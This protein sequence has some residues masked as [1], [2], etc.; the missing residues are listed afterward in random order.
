[1]EGSSRRR[2]NVQPTTPEHN[3]P[4]Q[5]I[6]EPRKLVAKR[7][8]K[9]S[10]KKT[11]EEKE[12]P[13]MQAIREK[14]LAK[15][16]KEKTSKTQ[17][18]NSPKN[19]TRSSTLTNKKVP[20]NE[21]D[22]S[23]KTSC[24]P[25]MQ[26]LLE[27]IGMKKSKSKSKVQK[28][29]VIE[30][31]NNKSSENL[32]TKQ[33]LRNKRRKDQRRKTCDPSLIAL[34]TTKKNRKS[35]KK[36]MGKERMEKLRKSLTM[37]NTTNNSLPL[38]QS[39][40]QKHGD[41]LAGIFKNIEV[42]LTRLRDE[43][44]K[45]KEPGDTASNNKKPKI[46][47]VETV[48]GVIKPSNDDSVYEEMDWEPLEDD[49]ITVEVKAVRT[50]LCTVNNE[51]V[52]CSVPNQSLSY[53]LIS[54]M[55]EKKQLYVVVDTNVFLSNINAI[56]LMKET[57]FKTFDH[58]F[59]VIPW[60][61]I[62]E[63]DYIKNSNSK[64]KSAALSMKARKAV[65]YINALFSSKYPYIIGQ[66][67]ED[68]S[69]NKEKYSIDCPD[70][71][72]LQT[73]LQIREF[74][75]SVVLLSYDTNLCTKAMIYDI[76]ALGRNDPFEKIDYLNALNYTNN[77]SFSLNEQSKDRLS[78]DAVSTLNS[79]QYIL[80]EIFDETKNVMRDFLTVIVSKEMHELY[81]ASWEE[82]V[83][84][85][86]PWTV[87]TVLQ[88]AIKHWIAA[89]SES[90]MRKA[91]TILKELL[92]I[93]RDK[94]GDKNLSQIDY[95]LNEC[96]KLIQMVNVVKYPDLMLRAIQKIDELKQQCRIFE[97]Q[98][99]Y[100]NLQHA[101]GSDPDKVLRERKAEKAFQYFEA[102]Y[103]FARDICGL[104]ASTVAMPCSFNYNFPYPLPP[105][106]YVKRIQPEL[107]ANVNR[108]LHTLSAV[109]EQAED[110]SNY[111]TLYRLH[112][113]LVMFF[114]DMLPI[115]IELPDEK[116]LPLDIYCCL[117]EK[118]EMLTTGLR[119]L[120]ELST[121]FCRLASYKCI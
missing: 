66:T 88:C 26:I 115:K 65:K 95:V 32:P 81:G 78:L 50:E 17:T 94:S 96:T 64:T 71:E 99:N 35:L 60:T 111:E 79:K 102:A 108:L 36:N 100:Q 21:I 14:I 117:K 40:V 98:L 67:R 12:T 59:I 20:Q 110:S 76:T 77:L 55:Q 43:V 39:M 49:K 68:A 97:N 5:E 120:Q 75:K 69:R 33:Q 42:R 119:Q 13:Q 101:I 10:E 4:G 70:D 37:E 112:Q 8:L 109:L 41:K 74:E 73:C 3:V 19:N 72:I 24:T 31:N 1:M 107:A 118:K 29:E 105:E 104:A 82:Y 28:V 15:K 114:P 103:T 52:S 86:P 106:D 113:A 91:E 63:L 57:K 44:P 38:E 51:D 23:A 87:V 48:F 56:E 46:L 61:V 22:G 9:E 62:R 47:S 34:T 27:K 84:M 90:F 53:P 30:D 89:V 25:Q 58:P 116:L 16:G 92:Q 80:N 54:E 2:K 45:N 6:K 18:S 85:K 93:F 121:H 7:S 11:N 83:I